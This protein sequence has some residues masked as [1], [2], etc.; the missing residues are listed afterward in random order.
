LNT[1]IIFDEMYKL[2][3]PSLCS[4]LEPPVTSSLL[5]KILSSALCSKTN[6]N[7]VGFEVLTV[8]TEEYCLLGCNAI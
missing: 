5:G 2:G 6:S 7:Y 4:F 1:L 8:V 3:D